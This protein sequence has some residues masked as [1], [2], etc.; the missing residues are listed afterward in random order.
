MTDR[1]ADYDFDLPQ[2]SIAQSPARPRDSARLLDVA[3]AGLIDRT[4]R[5]FP[6]LLRP[7][8]LLVANDTA[9][10]R[11]QL[12]ALRGEAKIGVTLDRILPDGSWHA[13]IRNA[14][15]LRVGDRL[16]FPGAR[17][18]DVA[19]VLELEDGGGATLRFSAEGDAF[20]AFLQ[21]AGALALPP[22]IHR[23]AGPT[24][25]DERDY[26]TIF[27]AHKGAVAAPTAGLHFTPDLLQ[28]I[29]AAGIERRTLTL[30]VGAG[31]FLPVRAETLTGHKM[32]AERG[33]VTA[34]TADAIN[35]ARARGGRVVAVGTT[36]LRLL[37]SAVDEQGVVRPFDGETS[38]FITPGFTFRAVDMLLTNFHLPRSTLFMLVSAFAGTARMRGAYA[39]A[40]R[41]GYRFYSYGDACLL[42]REDNQ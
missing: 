20:D 4:M 8:D 23:P 36:T 9:V 30:H 7:G 16:T 17:A 15:R 27:S 2:E 40:V 41:E 25:E 22:Y 12:H 28:R 31:T 26:T 32:H 6:D 42:R 33:V 3:E 19:D 24:S 13:L 18:E 1:T 39:H 29:D 11:A 14:R 34:E 38:I 35:A 10:I 37:E 5:E 21:A